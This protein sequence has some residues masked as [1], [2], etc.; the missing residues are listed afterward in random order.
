MKKGSD[1]KGSASS[2]RKRDPKYLGDF[3]ITPQKFENLP[4]V[5]KEFQSKE[6]HRLNDKRKSERVNHL[7][8]ELIEKTKPPCFLLP[9]V[10]DYIEQINTLKVLESYAFFH[11]ELWLN[12]FSHLNEEQNYKVRA[13]IA[14][15]EIPRDE[16]QILFP[17]GMG[18]IYPGSHFVTAHGSPDLDTTVASFWGWVDAFA[19]RVAEGLHLWN[20]PGGAPTSQI[21]IGLLFY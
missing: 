15:K 11:F 6:F 21:E 13:K 20:I 3:A 9:A 7:L 4:R 1:K 16:Y 18:K 12:Q 14:G 5:F 10:V 19:T 2:G 17:V 8:C